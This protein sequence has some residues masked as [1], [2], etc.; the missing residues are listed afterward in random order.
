MRFG[1]IGSFQHG[2]ISNQCS[3][4][5]F[6]GVNQLIVDEDGKGLKEL[7]NEWGETIYM[8]ETFALLEMVE[9]NPSGRY[10]VIELWNFKDDRKASLK[11]AI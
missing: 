4:T 7:R 6:F 1:F 2:H 3:F 9:Y 11:E 10:I 8:A 5:S